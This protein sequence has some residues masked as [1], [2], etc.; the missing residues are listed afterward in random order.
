MPFC[1]RRFAAS[2]ISNAPGTRTSVSC[3]FATPS[4]ASV[5]MQCRSNGFVTSGRNELLTIAMR[6]GLLFIVL[7]MSRHVF[8]EYIHFDIDH[9]A[10]RDMCECRATF[11]VRD[12]SD[13]KTSVVHFDQCQ[14][15]AVDRNGAFLRHV[16][17]ELLGSRERDDVAVAAPADT[18]DL[19][20]PVHVPLH[21][22]T[23]ETPVSF[24]R[25][26]QIDRAAL[27]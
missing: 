16:F 21:D 8:G 5:E 9:V 20:G 11:R 23:S 7:K 18:S 3:F 10:D 13:T 14:R 26:F 2:G 22:V 27:F 25:Q 17:R 12:N 4:R 15:N 24:Q 19:R 1:A 6:Y